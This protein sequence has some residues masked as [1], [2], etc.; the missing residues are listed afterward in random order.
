MPDN[1]IPFF[2]LGWTLIAFG[3]AWMTHR[4]D[5]VQT[6][7]VLCLAWLACNV[8]VVVVGHAKA[9]VLIPTID[10]ILALLCAHIAIFERGRAAIAVLFLFVMVGLVHVAAFETHT[11]GTY[12]YF[13][14]LNLLFFAQV[15]VVGGASGWAL[16]AD[17]VHRRPVRAGPHAFGA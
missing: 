2:Y 10:A 4:R 9:P 7:G 6:G 1:L 3:L 13:L 12:F 14:V 17:R 16:M 5:L 15:A 11:Q 8:A